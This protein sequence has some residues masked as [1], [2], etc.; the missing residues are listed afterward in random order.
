MILK[1]RKLIIAAIETILGFGMIAV[2]ALLTNSGVTVTVKMLIGIW[3][4]I[5]I[6]LFSLMVYD[7][8]ASNREEDEKEK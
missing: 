6:P 4:L 7:F 3:L 1:L 2:P 5:G 8:R